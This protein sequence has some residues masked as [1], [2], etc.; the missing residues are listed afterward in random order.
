[1]DN[2]PR[3]QPGPDP[4]SCGR[5]PADVRAQ[6]DERG[7][8]VI[9]DLIPLA[10]LEA[11][12][13]AVDAAVAVRRRGDTRTLAEKSR[14]EQSFQQCINLW[15]DSPAVRPLVFH[16]AV[17]EAACALLGVAAVRLW[18]DQALYKEASGRETDALQD[19]PYWPLAE[20]L[21]VTA[22]IPFDDVELEYGAMGYVPGSHRF[23][24][25]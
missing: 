13:R 6:F 8:V 3:S 24:V 5:L 19:Q 4:A 18:H 10:E 7:Y 1:M 9:P 15:E 17:A 11:F 2:S 25:R 14:Y 20:P 16:P 21:T 22:W 12:G 23:G